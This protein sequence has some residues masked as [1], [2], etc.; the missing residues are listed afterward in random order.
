M[1]GDKALAS[2]RGVTAHGP[3]VPLELE[4]VGKRWLIDA[5]RVITQ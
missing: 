5:S 3:F 1:H 4:R 2:F